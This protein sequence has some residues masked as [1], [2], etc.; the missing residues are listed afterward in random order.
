MWAYV[1]TA[2]LV[3]I[4]FLILA[5]LSKMSTPELRMDMGL[6][7]SVK[8]LI[9]KSQEAQA[10]AEQTTNPVHFLLNTNQAINYLDSAL[11][12]CSAKNCTTIAGFN[13]QDNYMTIM[14]QQENAALQLHYALNQPAALHNQQHQPQQPQQPQQHQRLDHLRARPQ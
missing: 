8:K 3:V 14:Q 12:L 9:T 1:R 7:Q 13:V 5:M 10:R 6:Q 11:V 2:G 4:V